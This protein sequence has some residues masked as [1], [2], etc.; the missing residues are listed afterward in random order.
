MQKV[1]LED[2]SAWAKEHGVELSAADLEG[3]RTLADQYLERVTA[4]R[5]LDLND[6]PLVAP[7]W[8]LEEDEA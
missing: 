2:L 3:V 5:R 7:R 1:H 8:A 6:E 4:L